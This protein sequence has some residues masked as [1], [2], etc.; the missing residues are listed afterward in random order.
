MDGKIV[1]GTELNTKEFDAQIEY[2][3]EKMLDIEDK[4]KQADMGFEVGDT[5][6]LEA[7]YERLGNQLL[8]LRERQEKYNQSIRDAQNLGL[9]NIQSALSNI[10]NS[11]Q[12]TTKKVARWA[13]AVFGVRSAYMAI[14]QAMNIIAQ[15]DQQLANDIQLMKAALAYTI[16][17]VVRT[18][19]NLAKQLMTY[20][21]YI[22]KAWTG[23][24]IFASA[25][26]SLAS[27]NKQAKELKNTAAAFDEFNTVGGA[28]S[29][30]GATAGFS[31]DLDIPS[32]KDMENTFIGWIAKNKNIV[33]A[34]LAGIAAGL[35]TIKIIQIAMSL[36]NPFAWIPLAVAAIVALVI[37]IVAK[38]DEIK[39]MF[40]KFGNWVYEK[41]IQPIGNFFANLWDKI[42]SGFSSA[43]DWIKSVF[44]NMV[45]FFKNI[46]NTITSLFKTI[47]EKGGQV[48]S[49]AF[50]AVVNG[51]LKAIES[52]LNTPIKAIN[53]LIKVINKVPGINL[54]QLT[55]F[56][57]PRLAKGGIVHNPG[58]GVLM[59]NYIAGEGRD[60]EAVLPLND[61][62]FDKLG[63][64]IAKHI[65]IT[66]DNK[67]YLNAR[68][69]ARQ[70]NIT[71]AENNF[72]Y[73]G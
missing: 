2:I 28:D 53:G 13:L 18:I 26:K 45:N 17:P 36:T 9:S 72:A 6:K 22:V 65:D 58:S 41:V 15:G 70:V 5:L 24:D 54:G 63:N 37:L 48:I 11:I 51:V 29:G 1:I 61:D 8:L 62:T 31:A 50:K 64:A 44:S 40:A 60:A 34:T 23:R 35:L 71:N 20:I 7:D 73:N 47:G 10:G 69:I 49:S 66:N 25:K 56:K 67:I 39:E 46:V 12:K 3:E 4:I 19:V 30:G 32:D 27:A 57:L 14:R 42:K 59:G 33:L 68:Q 38:W 43:I 21:A 55:E 52:I 16:E